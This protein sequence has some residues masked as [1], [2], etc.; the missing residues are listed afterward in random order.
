MTSAT[1]DFDWDAA[2]RRLQ[3]P[4]TAPASDDAQTR[5]ILDERARRLAAPIVAP[6]PGDALEVL[7]FVLSSGRYAIEH[8]CIHEVV[9]LH[10]MTPVPGAPPCVAGV[11][12]YHGNVLLLIDL[13]D[14]LGKRSTPLND[15]SRIIVLGERTPEFGLLAERT[16]ETRTIPQAALQ[17]MPICSTGRLPRRWS[18]RR[19]PCRAATG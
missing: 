8:A 11:T 2:R 10:S 18:N 9:R 15:L 17:P 4:R 7:T 6:T 14:V 19:R 16:D 1:R 5:K 3:Q 13:R 12:N